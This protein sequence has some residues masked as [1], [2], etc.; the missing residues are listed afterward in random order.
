ML[1]DISI[2]NPFGSIRDRIQA[3]RRRREERRIPE[4][5]SREEP[6]N[7]NT[8][9]KF[10]EHIPFPAAL[11]P[12]DVGAS[13][14]TAPT[15][16]LPEL[17][18]I[19]TEIT[20]IAIGIPTSIVTSQY[21]PK[22]SVRTLPT[23]AAVS[24]IAT[25]SW[26]AKSQVTGGIA[27]DIQTTIY[28]LVGVILFVL[29]VTVGIGFYLR[30]KLQSG[31]E[32]RGVDSATLSKLSVGDT[33]YLDF[34]EFDENGVSRHS[35]IRSSWKRSDQTS[36]LSQGTYPLSA[37]LSTA[38]GMSFTS[39]HFDVGIEKPM[40]SL[41]SNIPNASKFDAYP[42]LS[43]LSDLLRLES[44]NSRMSVASEES[45]SKYISGPIRKTVGI[46][47]MTNISSAS[48]NLIRDSLRSEE[49]FSQYTSNRQQLGIKRT[50]NARSSSTPV[51]ESLKTQ[52]SD[53][54]LSKYFK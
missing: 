49:S 30:K 37:H 26:A 39:D 51:R 9:Q 41:R 50:F 43:N 12:V 5:N 22:P 44:A 24:A 3:S 20:S 7:P 42:R 28:V 16:A 2:P 54:S 21:T 53:E 17:S 36:H 38:S 25:E 27:R 31:K 46:Q 23:L 29:I 45:L 19:V 32:F 33:Q 48:S 35:D 10:P 14:A 4:L 11:L 18:T 15:S 13:R 47:R 1:G 52:V 34:N 8:E 40:P 6:I